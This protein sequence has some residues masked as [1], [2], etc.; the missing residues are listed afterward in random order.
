MSVATEY[1][2]PRLP[3]TLSLFSGAAALTAAL[4]TLFFALGGPVPLT[5]PGIGDLPYFFLIGLHYLWGAAM[6]FVRPRLQ[7]KR[8]R[9]FVV[10]ADALAAYTLL[11][12]LFAWI[13]A[14][15]ANMDYV[16]RFV[17]AGGDLRLALDTGTERAIAALRYGPFL[18][19]NALFFLL[20]RVRRPGLVR[21]TAPPAMIE[22]TDPVSAHL[23][24]LATWGLLLTLVSVLLSTLSFPSFVH[25]DGIGPLGFI[26]LVPLLLA[27][28]GSSFRRGLFLG[29][30][31]GT[32]TTLLVNFWLGTFSLVSLQISVLIFFCFYLLFMM[33]TLWFYRRIRV[34]RFLVFPLA[35]TVFELARS[36][37]FLGYP[38]ALVGH[39]Q[40]RVLPLIQFATITGVW[41]VSFVVLLVNSALAELAAHLM[42]R[43]RE[44]AVGVPRV[45]LATTGAVLLL[46]VAGGAISLALGGRTSTDGHTGTAQGNSAARTV[47]IALIQQ[48]SDPRKHDY[49][50]T[51]E[52]LRRLTDQSLAYSPDI[53]AWS[54][55][56]FVPNIRRW[57]EENP[58][59]SPFARL[60]HEFREYQESIETW[61]LTGNDDY[62]RVFD[63]NNREID[64]HHFNA[65]VLF[66][67]TGERTQTYH[68]IR[69]VPFTEHFPY[70]HIFPGIHQLL[71]DFDVHFWEPGEEPVVFEHPLFRF[72]TPICFEDVFPNEVRQF[73]TAGA[74]VILNISN[75]YWSLTEVQAQQHFAAGMFR[76]VE[77]RR[78][79]VRSTASGLT[80]HVDEYGR[81]LATLPQYQE[82]YLIADVVIPERLRTTLYT[83]FGDW[84]PVASLLALVGLTLV[85]AVPGF[86]S[87]REVGSRRRLSFR[88]EQ[89]LPPGDSGAAARDPGSPDD[90]S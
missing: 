4:G 32:F 52:A 22:A 12:F 33:P 51:F 15:N 54:E 1:H 2:L 31:Y 50:Q 47:R 38:W 35:W 87:R 76:A 53:V 78:P 39:S 48:N 60:V 55:T 69:L 88:R 79:L 27:I 24:P 44:A 18:L 14:L 90:P 84:F 43:R 9:W 45:P 58:R 86:K 42:A 3:G 56:A 73:V 65:A 77:N 10:A 13:F 85:S 81:V 68:K 70:E 41:G 7:R 80:A 59:F 23:R 89:S 71:Q 36:S 64:R 83:R 61:L 62:A 30:A 75:D 6:I 66:S 37:G 49:D 63:E 5:N 11:L 29:V 28:R 20:I 16:Q 57:G 67:D 34:A 19:V 21:A 25:A 8:L 46:V 17:E 74:E 72:S 40:Y 26:S 82:A